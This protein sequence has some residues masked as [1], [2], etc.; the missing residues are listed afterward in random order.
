MTVESIPTSPDQ[1]VVEVASLMRVRA[2]EKKLAFTIEYVGAIPET[3][4][5]DPTRLRQILLNFVGNAIKFT[6]KGGVRI[7][8]RCDA[9]LSRDPRLTIEV[10]DDGIGLTD[11]ELRKLFTAFTQADASTTRKFGGSGLG[12]VISQRFSQ[13]LGGEITVESKPGQGSLF[14][15]AVPTGPLEGVRMIEGRVEARIVVGADP[16]L[17]PGPSLPASCRVLLAE[18]GRDNQVL[19]TTFLVKAGATVKV[20]ENGQLAVEE[21]H[22]AL[23]GGVPYDVVLMDMQMPVLD[24]YSATSKLRMTGYRGPIVAV[25]AH[26]MAG[27]RERCESAGCD[28]YLTKPVDRA[29]LTASVARFAQ[30]SQAP[31]Q[32]LVSTLASDDDLEE[33]VRQY[34]LALPERSSAIMRAVQA[35]DV[36]TLKVLAH[37]LKGSAGAYGFQVITDAAA[38]VE[39]AVAS[40][41]DRASIEARAGELAALCR[42]ARAA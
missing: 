21:A 26:A 42:R 2:V 37:Q 7:L 25:T 6:A 23:A 19:I 34:A 24:G 16:P 15:V 36:E 3:I 11:M 13:L 10:S 20:V 38:A 27:D 17:Q 29:K 39:A 31:G 18:D 35:S 30:R 8:V 12:L 1:I 4:Q 41:L 28:D 32:H 14:R 5:S 33:L 40:G 9:P 22:A